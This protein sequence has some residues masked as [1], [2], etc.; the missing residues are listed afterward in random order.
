MEY[1]KLELKVL[2][3]SRRYANIAGIAVVVVCDYGCCRFVWFI[4]RAVSPAPD[5]EPSY[6][7]FHKDCE[8][9]MREGIAL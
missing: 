6:Q 7:G 4:G 8:E 5:N 3:G 2:N 9:E 1:F